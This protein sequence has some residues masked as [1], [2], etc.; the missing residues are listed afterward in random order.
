MLKRGV[1]R[2]LGPVMGSHGSPR[3]IA[4]GIIL[5]QKRPAQRPENA[6]NC[7]T[8]DE[9]RVLL[10]NITECRLCNIQGDFYGIPC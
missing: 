3:S 8:P 10:C 2:L 6:N 5:T 1:G 4:I 7:L 9:Y